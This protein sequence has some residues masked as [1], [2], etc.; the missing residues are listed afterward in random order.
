[1]HANYWRRTLEVREWKNHKPW[2]H[3][4]AKK[5]D[6]TL[7]I[8]LQ[9]TMSIWTNSSWLQVAFKCLLYVC[10]FAV[11]QLFYAIQYFP[12][13]TLTHITFCVFDLQISRLSESSS[14][15]LTL[16]STVVQEVETICH[17]DTVSLVLKSL[18][19]RNGRCKEKCA[20][21]YRRFFELIIRCA[22]LWIYVISHN[23]C[24]FF[25]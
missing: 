8:L 4:L 2:R 13:I 7:K 20:L 15:T 25:E 23:W 1:M 19:T 5:V 17:Q 22:C 11:H 14:H 6:L 24:V 3:K 18:I 10:I 21:V 9:Q 12:T 16:V